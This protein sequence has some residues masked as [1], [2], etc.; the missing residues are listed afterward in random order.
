MGDIIKLSEYRDWLRDLKQTIKTGQIKAALSVN[1]QM[2]MLY[3][4]L[5]RQ[6]KAVTAHVIAGLTRNPLK[7][8]EM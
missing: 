5:G 4:N 3:W 8:G 6:R 7:K 2:I 1:S